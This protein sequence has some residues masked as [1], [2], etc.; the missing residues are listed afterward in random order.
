MTE[1]EDLCSLCDVY[2]LGGLDETERAEFEQHLQT[3]PDCRA[4]LPDLLATADLLLEHYAQ[5]TPP[6]GMRDRVLA[7]VF[8]Q[9]EGGESKSASAT[10]VDAVA[11]AATGPPAHAGTQAHTDTQAH[12][13][14]RVGR[15]MPARPV[16]RTWTAR[17][18]ARRRRRFAMIW[19][20]TV[21][22]IGVAALII[23]ISLRV[24]PSGVHPA[25]T[26]LGQASLTGTTAML[27]AQGTAWIEQVQ[28]GKSLY[29]QI[30]GLKRPQGKQIYEVWLARER[31]GKLQVYPCGVFRPARDGNAVFACILPK[32]SYSL[33][34]IT[35]EPRGMDDVPLGPKVLLGK[36]AV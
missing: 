6:P 7:A 23:A 9:D 31:A 24:S 33:I 29:M 30:S 1:H 28:A 22:V 21:A 4:R 10:P 2:A 12:A 18:F 17:Q 36:A 11:P 5:V 3:C 8:A 19:P 26:L 32:G 35:L 27:S 16:S 20:V 25:G 34:A 14:Q 13:D 15:G